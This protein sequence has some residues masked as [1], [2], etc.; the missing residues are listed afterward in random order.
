[1]A[2][3]LRLTV[4]IVDA[5]PVVELGSMVPARRGGGRGRGRGGEGESRE[6]VAFCFQR[7]ALHTTRCCWNELRTR[8]YQ[9]SSR[10]TFQSVLD[11]WLVG[12]SPRVCECVKFLRQTESHFKLRVKKV[13]LPK[14]TWL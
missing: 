1:V 14:A 8:G 12:A 10:Q 9:V 4:A 7:T 5:E 3:P 13:V 11:I 2:E 6:L